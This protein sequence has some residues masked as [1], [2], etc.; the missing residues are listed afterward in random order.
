MKFS[1]QSSGLIN[2]LLNRELEESSE[3]MK[4]ILS[5]I[6]N[7][8]DRSLQNSNFNPALLKITSDLRESL[9]QTRCK[10]EKLKS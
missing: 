7:I 2:S 8:R 4:V 1:K 9:F 3:L 6:G 10:L 5:E